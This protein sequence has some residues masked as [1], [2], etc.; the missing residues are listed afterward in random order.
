MPALQCAGQP[1]AVSPAGFPNASRPPLSTLQLTAG[2][3]A[4]WY[5]VK[6]PL[7]R[8]MG[9]AVHLCDGTILFVNGAT[10]GVA[11][12]SLRV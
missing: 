6:M 2:K 8:V 5:G 1:S 9:D 10:Q 12:S 3:N 4:P 7:G 11:V